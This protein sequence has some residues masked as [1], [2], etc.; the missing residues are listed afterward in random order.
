VEYLG[1]DTLIDTRIAIN[2][3][4]CACRPRDAHVGDTAHIRWDPAAAH[5]FNLSTQRRI[6]R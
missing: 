1:A 6:D 5:W 2:P 3:S 4:S